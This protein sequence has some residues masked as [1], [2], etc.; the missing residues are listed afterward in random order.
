M[1][2]PKLVDYNNIEIEAKFLLEKNFNIKE[3]LQLKNSLGTPV[4]S[5]TINF[6]QTHKHK[7]FIK[8][9]SFINGIQDKSKK[10]IILKSLYVNQ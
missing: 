2:L 5:Q 7:M 8:Q 4:M 10:K 1:N 9:I 3:F 6:I